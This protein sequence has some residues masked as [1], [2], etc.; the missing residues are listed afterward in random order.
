M[1]S[2]KSPTYFR[3]NS[4][5]SIP[6]LPR[7]PTRQDPSNNQPPPL[8][9]PNRLPPSSSQNQ[10][11]NGYQN[12]NGRKNTVRG[13]VRGTIREQGSAGLPPA[14]FVPT[15]ALTRG[16]TLTRPDRFVPPA[17]LINPNSTGKNTTGAVVTTKLIN[18]VPTLVTEEPFWDPWAF[19]V[20]A[21]TFWAPGFLLK[22]CSKLDDRAK[23]RAWKEKVALCMII[24]VMG[25]AVAFLTIGLTRVLCPVSTGKGP[26]TFTRLGTEG[27]ES[28]RF[29]LGRGGADD[30]SFLG[31]LGIEGWNFNVS[32]ATGT[33]PDLLRL[34]KALSGQDITGFFDQS[35]QIPASCKGKTARYATSNLCT[36]ATSTTCPFGAPSPSLFKSLG[37]SNSTLQ[38]G[39]DWDQAAEYKN[40]MVLDGIVLNMNSYL[41]ANPSAIPN[42][43]VDEAIRFVLLKMD[44]TGGKDATR[45]FY[46]EPLLIGSAG[47]IQD[48]YRAGH[49]DK[50]TPG[51]FASELFL[52]F[53]L[54]VILAVV[55]TRLGMAFIFKWFLAGK[56]VREPKVSGRKVI[57]PNVMPE[58]ANV[59]VGNTTGA[60]PWSNGTPREGMRLRKGAGGREKE[61]VEEPSLESGMISMASIGAELFCVCLV[62]CYSEGEE[63]IRITL[64]S[65]AATDYS[66]ARKLLFIVCDGIVTGG[67]EKQNTP[68]IVV[69]MLE[70]DER[71]GEPIGM[72][73]EAV[74]EGSKGNNM[75]LVYAGHYSELASLI[76]YQEMEY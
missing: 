25:G 4:N 39:F 76:R 9:H 71:F 37:I 42:D 1:N 11:G 56:L 67:G 30:F 36:T 51:C 20:Y 73:Y 15:R 2:N 70:R 60:A 74:A 40:Y 23:Q 52:Y 6:P 55:L 34:A 48:R 49:I 50:I 54:I 61:K 47:C 35:T 65:I 45:I 10:N 72:S 62:T 21:V 26:A 57:S 46:N 29:E 38:V 14:N 13:A 24:V 64:D 27:G 12:G 5:E 58:G 69:G 44:G 28:I 8:L 43:P 66:D 33:T 53:S 41:F 32:G 22:S 68:D 16:K 31:F 7:L 75:A 19:F 3:Q 63:G 59:D 17:P 18:G